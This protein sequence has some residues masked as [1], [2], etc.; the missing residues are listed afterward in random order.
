MNVS[1]N[2]VLS[3]G[4]TRGYA[5][6]GVIKALYEKGITANAISG[7]SA[8]ALIGAFICDGFHPLEIEEIVVK[9]EPKLGFNY[10]H[11]WDNLLTFNAFTQVIKK[12]L[13]TRSLENLRTP[14][15]V[16]VTNL[17]TGLQEIITQGSIIDA[18]SAS[19]AIPM[20]LPAVFINGVPY[21]DGGISNNLPVAPFENAKEKIIGVHV[22]P[23][24]DF[25]KSAGMM[26]NLDRA[27][28]L[29]MLGGVT[30]N[31]KSCTV[32]IEPPDLKAFHAF[33]SNKSKALIS[34]GYNYVMDGFNLS[35][36]E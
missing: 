1:C 2:F 16:A 29:V 20:A 11:F 32:F 22:N 13:R 12:N 3:G 17:N 19:A 24:P 14:L 25:T 28:T 10:K 31:K 35:G 7:A 6:I 33:E 18:L 8:G 34:I 36:L 26:K 30:N 5:H 27:M 9:N 21:A 4:G 15:H 23:L